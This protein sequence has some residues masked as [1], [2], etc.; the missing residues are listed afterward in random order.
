[1]DF[2]GKLGDLKKSIDE[3]SRVK[4][5]ADL[6]IGTVVYVEKD[7]N[8]GLTLTSGYTT[9]LKYVVVAGAKS[10]KKEVCAVLMN[11]DAD[12]S[13]DPTWRA[14]QYLLLQRDYPGILD[15]DS[16]L[17]C[18]DPKTLTVRK[19]KAKKAEVKGH[20][21]DDD[22]KAV[23]SKLKNSEFI[24]THLKKIYGILNYDTEVE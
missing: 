2:K 12:Y 6:T 7:K 18:T 21:T 15:Y 20:L 11:T 9:R 22:L 24:S 17:D 8:D 3:A 5:I 4:S 16:W 23:M 13:D 14:D 19:L 1:M 10:D